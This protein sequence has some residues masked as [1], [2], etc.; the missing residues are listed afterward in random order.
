[1]P[2]VAVADWSDNFDGYADGTKLYNVGGW[3]G[4]DDD[5][6]AAGTVSSAQALSAPHSIV[7]SNDMGVDAVHP[8]DP[9]YTEG[10]WTF[11]AWQYI[12]DNLDGATYFILNNVYAP[13]THEWAM[14]IGMDPATGMVTEEIHG[15]SETPIVYDAWTEIRVEFD[16]DLDTADAYYN[17]VLIY[18]GSWT[19]SGYPTPEFA[20]VDL[21][22][23]HD[24]GVYYDDISLVPE[25]ASCLLL[26]L[27]V[28]ALR[29]R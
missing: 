21:Y 16:L 22:A 9:P 23:P 8:F 12:P 26:V 2:A 17:N 19:S 7:V 27:G 15:G 24:V 18:S 28:L 29:R 11:T 25:P 14:Q 3:S 20:N 10:A 6:N 4:W 1:M 13:P 5:P